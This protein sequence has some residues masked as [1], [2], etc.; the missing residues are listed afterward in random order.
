[1]CWVP[2]M[3]LCPIWWD[4]ACLRLLLLLLLLHLLFALLLLVSFLASHRR[5]GCVSTGFFLLSLLLRRD[6]CGSAGSQAAHVKLMKGVMKTKEVSN[7]QVERKLSP[8]R[9]V[10]GKSAAHKNTHLTC[11]SWFYHISCVTG[12]L[13]P[14]LGYIL[15]RALP[16]S[17]SSFLPLPLS[18]SLSLSLSLC[19][20]ERIDFNYFWNLP[21]A[22][23]LF[24]SAL[25]C[26]RVQSHWDALVNTLLWLSEEKSK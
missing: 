11:V 9:S 17:F 14:C 1:M 2:E 13:V 19:I 25:S 3:C 12:F 20:S 16:F 6:D 18:F 10:L 22:N 23:A 24:L 8:M 21:D 26:A 5:N 15:L 4:G 7:L